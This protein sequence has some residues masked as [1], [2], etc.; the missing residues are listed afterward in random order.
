[1]SKKLKTILSEKLT[2]FFESI[3][4]KLLGKLEGVLKE[5]VEKSL[6]KI[7]I[8]K[9]DGCFCKLRDDLVD[10][11]SDREDAREFFN[12]TKKLSSLLEEKIKNLVERKK[13]ELRKK[14]KEKV[15]V[16]TIR[17]ALSCGV[18]TIA[19][20][21]TTEILKCLRQ[22]NDLQALKRKLEFDFEVI[23]H[24][25]NWLEALGIIERESTSGRLSEH[26]IY[27]TSSFG[28]K[29][30]EENSMHNNPSR[31]SEQIY[32][33]A[34]AATESEKDAEKLLNR[35]FGKWGRDH[36]G[37]LEKLDKK[38]GESFEGMS[39]YFWERM[40]GGHAN[41]IGINII[42]HEVS[43]MLLCLRLSSFHVEES[44]P[45]KAHSANTS[46]LSK[47]NMSKT[48]ANPA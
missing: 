31:W 36:R 38:F 12:W 2:G 5:E 29:V 13:Q 26:V 24:R 42:N 43:G 8:K 16:P 25:I 39:K 6:K 9:S 22:G 23:K 46:V 47:C 17:G 3:G 41:H 18:L 4:R 28:S 27:R 40:E 11:L 15:L 7:G 33:I 30:L 45:G 19:D 44:M 21:P 34:F 37:V 35:L 32:R 20:R 1:M 14:Y 10:I 48:V